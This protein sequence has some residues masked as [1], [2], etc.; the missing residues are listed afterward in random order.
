MSCKTAI[1]P[2]FVNQPKQGMLTRRSALLAIAGAAA[3]L[4]G[5]GGGGVDT[6]GLSSG[7]TGS[8]TSGTISGFGSI[9]VNGIRYNNDSASVIGS[10]GAS[11]SNTSLKLGM[12]VNIEGSAVTPASTAGALP[13]A[14]AYSISF[15]S[16]WIGPVSSINGQTFG[17]LGNTVDV[18]SSTVVGGVIQAYADLRTTH[19]VE[20]Y[21]YVDGVDGHVQASRIDVFDVRPS[22]YKLSG[23]LFSL[24]RGDRSAT[25]GRTSIEWASAAD[26]LSPIANGDFVLVRLNPVPSRGVWIATRI[27][28]QSSAT[29][30]LSNERSYEAEIQGSITAYTSAANFT[31]NGVVVDA[32]SAIVTGSL[33]VGVV[34]EVE[35]T[36]QAGVLTAEKVEVKSSSEI[37]SQEFVFYGVLS[38]LTEST[39]VVR[40]QTFNYDTNTEHMNRITGL[41]SP[42]VKVKAIR[43]NGGMYATEIELDD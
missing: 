29:A 11:A 1:Q 38:N 27:Q 17:I 16:E 33:A 21:G 3:E 39:F 37:E 2:I 12:M 23:A 7:G 18:L 4:A 42:D 24:D 13:V 20:V 41:T 28:L 26:L 15:D 30:T 25:V 19:F 43:V 8:F 22:E 9:I 40:G 14:T 6:A 10:D 32:T 35:G 31:V 5:C 34:V 36:I